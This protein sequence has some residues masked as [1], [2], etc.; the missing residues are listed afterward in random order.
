MAHGVA[1][2]HGR[3][4]AV[5]RALAVFGRSRVGVDF[6]SLDGAPT[7][8]F[9]GLLVPGAQHGLHLKAL[10]RVTRLLK[11]AAIRQALLDAPDAGALY[12]ILMTEDAR[13]S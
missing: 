8:L 9:F 7:H 2:P 1:I 4:D 11:E 10:A 12:Q 13:L 5:G 3:T 6:Q